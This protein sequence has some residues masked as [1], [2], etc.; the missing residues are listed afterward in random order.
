MKLLVWFEYTS[1]TGMVCRIWT[2]IDVPITATFLDAIRLASEEMTKDSVYGPFVTDLEP[3]KC[4][5]GMMV[6]KI[7]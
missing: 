6:K 7:L 2:T 5:M 1:I 3:E 4:G